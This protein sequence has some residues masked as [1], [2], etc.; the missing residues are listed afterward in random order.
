MKTIVTSLSQVHKT[1]KMDAIVFVVV[2]INLQHISSI[3]FADIFN[4]FAVKPVSYGKKYLATFFAK[5]Q[6]HP[7]CRYHAGRA[8]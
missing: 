3:F 4:S 2:A 8:N 6:L 1:K 7:C 5:H